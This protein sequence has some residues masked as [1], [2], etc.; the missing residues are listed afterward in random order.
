MTGTWNLA[1]RFQKNKLL[2]HVVFSST[3]SVYGEQNGILKETDVCLPDNVY[4]VS[5]YASE[6]ILEQFCGAQKVGLSILRY[7][8]VYGPDMNA[9]TV[10]SR[11]IGMAKEGK[12]LEVFGDGGR[13]QDFVHLNDVVNANLAACEKQAEGIFNVGCGKKTT[14]KELAEIILK[15]YGKAR[16]KIVLS[17]KPEMR[18]SQLMSLQKSESELGYRPSLRL[19]DGIKLN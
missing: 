10:I 4:A 6:R 2:R 12:D 5:K 13:Y 9:E 19:D 8:S 16:Q 15:Q 14:M 1:R 3:I 18:P 17:G 11:F 7:G